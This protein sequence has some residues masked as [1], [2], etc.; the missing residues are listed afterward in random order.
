MSCP[1]LDELLAWRSQRPV[2]DRTALEA[3][4]HSG[5][6]NCRRQLQLLHVLFETLGEPAPPIVSPDLRRRVLEQLSSM[7]AEPATGSAR[8]ALSS[9]LGRLKEFIAEL[10]EPLTTPTLA[11]G[12]RGESDTSLRRYRAGPF[13]LDVGLVE[14][15]AVLG[16]LLD[17]DGADAEGFTGSDCILCGTEVTQQTVMD[18]DASFRFERAGPGRF[19]LM[20]ESPDVRLVFPDIDLAVPED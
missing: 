15:R 8:P 18:D 3:H 5:C 7:P 11:L 9:A 14:R 10:I 19:A 17:E 12:L 20:I 13:V 1:P 6:P 2:D 4:L 16:Q